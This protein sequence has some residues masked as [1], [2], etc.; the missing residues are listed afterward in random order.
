MHGHKG[1]TSLVITDPEKPSPDK[2]RTSVLIESTLCIHNLDSHR[3]PTKNG[4]V[5]F[6][7]LQDKD[8]YHTDSFS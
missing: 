7:F 8:S 4:Y 5:I 1:S 3:I 2:V 6:L